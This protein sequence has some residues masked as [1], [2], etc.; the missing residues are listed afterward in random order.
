[1]I[2]GCIGASMLVAGTVLACRAERYV[3][4]FEQTECA[5]GILIVGGL[6]VI[7]AGLEWGLNALPILSR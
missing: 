5:A 7:G 3:E 6:A 2:V 4:R 1:M